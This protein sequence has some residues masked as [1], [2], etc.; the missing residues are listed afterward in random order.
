L[1]TYKNNLPNVPGI[2]KQYQ[3]GSI[4]LQLKGRKKAK[5]K[6]LPL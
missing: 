6:L 3:R 1:N 2:F 4:L 5:R